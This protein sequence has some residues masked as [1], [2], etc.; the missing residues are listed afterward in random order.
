M[1]ATSHSLSLPPV[2]AQL[3]PQLPSLAPAKFPRRDRVVAALFVLALAVPFLAL[4]FTWSRT[5][6]LFEKRA[7]APWPEFTPA[8]SF[9]PAFERAFA[10]RFGGRDVLIRLHHASLIRFFGVSALAT[11]MPGRDGWYYCLGEDGLSLDRHYR[12]VAAFPQ[13]YVDGTVAEL[14]RRRDWLGAR[15]IAFIVA[16]VPEKFTIYP[17]HLPAWVAKSEQPSPYDRVVAALQGSG[18]TLI[19]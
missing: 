17:E 15:N 14:V 5:M 9:P 12:G 16:V 10:D 1:P 19:D 13:A 11:V 4:T 3:P 18:V 8:T 6:T 2:P 7:M